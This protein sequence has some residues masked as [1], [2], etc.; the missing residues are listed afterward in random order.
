ME[1][2]QW[3]AKIAEAWLIRQRHKEEFGKMEINDVTFWKLLRGLTA[4]EWAQW[5]L[6]GNEYNT[7]PT[8]DVIE[9]AKT[10][11][12]GEHNHSD[13]N[14]TMW[15]TAMRTMEA[16]DKVWRQRDIGDSND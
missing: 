8:D 6:F 1:N 3:A 2:K 15:K 14:K 4:D 5:L 13:H 16:V 7:I 10:V 9:W 12:E 11:D